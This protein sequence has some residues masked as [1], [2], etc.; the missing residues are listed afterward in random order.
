M[1]DEELKSSLNEINK[2]LVDMKNKKYPGVWRAF[3][4]GMFS[5]FGYLVGIVFVIFILG[6]FLNL[7]GVL[8]QVEKQIKDFQAF[9]GSAQKLMNNT[10][11][12]QPQ[13]NNQGS[14]MITLPDG[15]KA[16]VTP[17]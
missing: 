6:W 10:D 9:M 14:Y 5:A 17:Q 7:I 1:I 8:P 15:R 12:T 11:N 13:S 3:F 16:E 2:N 4:Q